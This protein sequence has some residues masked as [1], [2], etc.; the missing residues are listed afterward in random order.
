MLL[1][2]SCWE[3]FPPSIYRTHTEEEIRAAKEAANRELDKLL[4]MLEE[5]RE[6]EKIENIS[7]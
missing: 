3:I 4:Q 2:M 6:K 1:G 7:G 5:R